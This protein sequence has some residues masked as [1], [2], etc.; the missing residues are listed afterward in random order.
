MRNA[1][2]K[3]PVGRPGRRWE[4]NI[5]RILNICDLGEGLDRINWAGDR[6]M[7]R[8]VVNAVMNLCFFHEMGRGEGFLDQLRNC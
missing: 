1:E 8:A 2:R 5:K 4:D 3:R 7:G 6:D